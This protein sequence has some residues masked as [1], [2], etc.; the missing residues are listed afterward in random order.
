MNNF[1][2]KS[3]AKDE[4]LVALK[5]LIR[6]G[7]KLLI[8]H[9]IFGH[10]DIPGGRIR[11]DQFDVPLN[12]I[13][14]LKIKEELGEEITYKIEDIKTVLRVEREEHGLNGKKVRIFGVCYEVQ[15][16]GGNPK[17]GDHHDKIEWIDITSA[18]LDDYKS[19]AGW[20]HLLKDYQSNNLTTNDKSN[21]I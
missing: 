8:T 13:L 19:S 12:E 4:Y 14:D 6:D 3:A 1:N 5:A 16:L 17:I 9:D 7:N 11:K 20:V 15:Y 10:W 21:N 2:E 18:N